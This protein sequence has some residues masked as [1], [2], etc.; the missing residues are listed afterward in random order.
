MKI[1]KCISGNIDTTV[2]SYLEHPRKGNIFVTHDKA[3]KICRMSHR[4]VPHL[5][6]T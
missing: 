1:G 5:Y 6:S 2:L 4:K 3:S